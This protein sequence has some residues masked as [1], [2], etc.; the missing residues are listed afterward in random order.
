M[1]FNGPL[2]INSKNGQTV[3]FGEFDGGKR[4][5]VGIQF[6]SNGGNY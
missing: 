2:L 6:W 3:Y 5:G 1:V 4:E